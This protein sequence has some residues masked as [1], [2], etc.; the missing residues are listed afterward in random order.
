MAAFI[1]LAFLFM[2]ILC[3]MCDKESRFSNSFKTMAAFI[4]L[5]MLSSL[6][7][8]VEGIIDLLDK[9]YMNDVQVYVQVDEL[10]ETE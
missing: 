9:D 7:Q 8:A 6:F 3:R 5:L 4:I 10:C 2:R 1:V